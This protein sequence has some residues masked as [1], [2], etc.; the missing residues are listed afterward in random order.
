MTGAKC[1]RLAVCGTRHID[2]LVGLGAEASLVDLSFFYSSPYQMATKYEGGD[3]IIPEP[4]T[5]GLLLLGGL[6]LLRCK[7]SA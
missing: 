2:V 3:E 6:V 7:L 1:D 5:L 4:A